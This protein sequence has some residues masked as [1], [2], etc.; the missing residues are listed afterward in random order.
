MVKRV[1]VLGGTFD[2]VHKGHL[3]IARSFLDSGL[4]D[5][6][7]I[8]PA[9]FPPHKK[10]DEV[11]A[12]ADRKAMLE[13]AFGH[14][15]KV[16]ICTIEEQLPK[17]S[18]TLQTITALKE[19]YPDLKFYLCLGSDSL[20]T[21]SQW[22]RYKEI[23]K[24]CSLL[25]AKRPG[26]DDHQ[27]EPEILEKTKFIDHNPVQVSSTELKEKMAGSNLPEEDLPEAVVQYIREKKLYL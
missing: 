2:P 9:A 10:G 5:E 25:V 8:V 1:G 3:A 18:Y 19:A 16:R 4:I 15:D 21:F 26:F 6:L 11:T 13:L 20:V 17:P 24:E 23:L 27:I 22:H 7:W 14:W 12:Y